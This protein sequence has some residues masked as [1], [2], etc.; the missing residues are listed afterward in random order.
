MRRY[1]KSQEGA[2]A[3]SRYIDTVATG[4]NIRRL[5][6]EKGY[7]VN[8]LQE[9]LGPSCPQGIYYWQRGL[10]PAEHR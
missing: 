7:S 6:L 9:Y 5:R 10:D 4:W 1:S 8:V 2:A 3:L